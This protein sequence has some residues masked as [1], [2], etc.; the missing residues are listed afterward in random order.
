L[1]PIIEAARRN[2]VTLLFSPDDVE[3]NNAVALREYLQGSQQS[4]P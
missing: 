3:H 2:T 1:Q 4:A